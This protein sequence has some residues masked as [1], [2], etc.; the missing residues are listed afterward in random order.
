MAYFEQTKLTNS[1]GTVINPAEKQDLYT[2]DPPT[3][4]PAPVVRTAP[5]SIDDQLA[6][7]RR[8]AKVLESTAAC[9]PQQRQR[10]TI[11]SITAGVTLPTVTTVGT[12]TTVTGVTTVSTVT[13][14]T[15]IAG[16]LG[17]NQQAFADP[18]RTAYNTGIR[19]QITFG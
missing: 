16:L 15:N 13:S 1:S 11:D 8:I 5:G 4:A 2:F 3:D 17:W 14:V 9:D 19:S 12:V 18:A 6:L 10:L 7:L